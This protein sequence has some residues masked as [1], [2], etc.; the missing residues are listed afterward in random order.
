M[1]CHFIK[2]FDFCFG[3][4]NYF[5]YSDSTKL[6]SLS[7]EGLLALK[8]MT[9]TN[10]GMTSTTVYYQSPSFG[11]VAL[12]YDDDEKSYPTDTDI[13]I[14]YDLC[15]I[16]ALTNIVG[17]EV[18]CAAT[19]NT[20][21]FFKMSTEG[22]DLY[23]NGTTW[24]DAAA[25][26]WNTEAEIQTG[27]SSIHSYLVSKK[28]GIKV[29]LYTSDGK[30]TPIIKYIRFLTEV[31]YEQEDDIL[32]RSL[33]PYLLTVRPTGR[34]VISLEKETDNFNI[35]T[36]Y[37]PDEYPL[38]IKDVKH[39]YLNSDE[40]HEN[41]LLSSYDSATGLVTLTAL[42]PISTNLY[43]RYEYQPEVLAPNTSPDWYEVPALPSIVMESV[44]D[45]KIYTTPAD[46]IINYTTGWG[47]EFYN[48]T[49]SQYT[50]STM[51]WARNNSEMSSLKDAV[52]SFVKIN[53]YITSSGLDEKIPI[54]YQGGM[55]SSGDSNKKGLASTSLVLI[56]SFIN[57][58]Y[59]TAT[60]SKKVN[61]FVVTTK[62]EE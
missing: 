58:I 24:E 62:L 10:I 1:Q 61:K 3:P 36:D 33:I 18:N 54:R 41:D 25:T 53:R 32:Y 23:W 13:Y 9:R 37:Q 11:G 4:S 40:L 26:D 34:I 50:I 15:Q 55:T 57:D 59:E 8:N 19:T 14:T 48:S 52:K 46:S 28:F 35:L 22:K 21:V 31:D 16:K 60:E 51:L 20:S 7:Y 27:L 39:V 30:Y 38:D 56:I 5:E 6:L 44:T 29:R 43:V 12:I 2:D 17:F 42:Q 45:E 49:S 47:Y